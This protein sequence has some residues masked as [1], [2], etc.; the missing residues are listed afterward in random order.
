LSRLARAAVLGIIVTF[1]SLLYFR[2]FNWPDYHHIE[3]GLP[4][5][6]LVRTLSTIIGP[7]DKFTFQPTS[8]FLDWFFWSLLALVLLFA[9]GR[10]RGDSSEHA[11]AGQ[12]AVF[13]KSN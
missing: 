11:R 12:Q 8:F 4:V 5:A 7:T 9:V 1:F 6:W 13:R 10:F 3:Y 2:E